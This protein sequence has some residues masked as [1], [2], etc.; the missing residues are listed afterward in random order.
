MKRSDPALRAAP[1]HDT[2][3]RLPRA[4]VRGAFYREHQLRR[5][6]DG[7]CWW[8][9]GTAAGEEPEG[10]FDLPLPRGSLYL[11]STQRV[12]SRERCGRFLAHHAPIPVTFVQDRVVTELEGELED[13][14]D[15]THDAAADLGVTREI[16]TIDDYALT[17]A[18]ATAAEGM[19]FAGL[20]YF[21]RFTTGTGTACAVFGDAGA[22]P[23]N[24]FRLVSATSLVE[25][26][27]AQGIPVRTLPAAHDVIDDDEDSVDG[28]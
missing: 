12:A 18:W 5:G 1:G 16:A 27:A 26:L 13:L 10:R 11:A 21:P 20:R 8:F 19:G 28:R 6:D 14:A 24:G 23:P 17:A 25:V 22:H 2:I 9:S 7:G 15:L 3:A 4:S